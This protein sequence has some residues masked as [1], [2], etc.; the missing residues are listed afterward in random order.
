MSILTP[1]LIKAN[2]ESLLANLDPVNK[3][4]YYQIECPSCGHREAFSYI[5]SEWINC[6]RQNKC[7]EKIHI[8]QYLKE[9]EGLSE[10]QILGLALEQV[11]GELPDVVS[12]KT[13]QVEIPNEVMFFAKGADS[14]LSRAPRRYLE[15][16]GLDKESI[17][18]LGYINNSAS[19]FTKRIFIPFYENEKIVYF[20]ARDYTGKSKLRYMNPTGMNS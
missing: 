16:R 9:K 10:K 17:E 6:G 14:I 3:G 5:G 11:H 12:S 7:G 2:Q 20:V 1:E 4:R 19:Q 13:S 15:G 8:E 18:R